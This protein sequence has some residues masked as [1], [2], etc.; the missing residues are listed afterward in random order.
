MH[1]TSRITHHTSPTGDGRDGHE[2]LR[3]PFLC[4]RRHAA[5]GHVADQRRA[6]TGAGGGDGGGDSAGAGDGDGAGVG[7]ITALLFVVTFVA[8]YCMLCEPQTTLYSPHPTPTQPNS[9]QHNP[10]QPIPSHPIPS[11]PRRN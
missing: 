1:H 9:T 10:L 2:V 7:A 11:H 4:C 8:C 5:H 6:G 3:L